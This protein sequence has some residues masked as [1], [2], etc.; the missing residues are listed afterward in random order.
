MAY[1][2]IGHTEQAIETLQ[3]ALQLEPDYAGRDAWLCHHVLAQIEAP[4]QAANHRLAVQ[5]WAARQIEPLARWPGL[6]QTFQ[7]A[8]ERLQASGVDPA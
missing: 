7:Q 5:Q 3:R 2:A 8:I 1:R 6:Q 4:Q